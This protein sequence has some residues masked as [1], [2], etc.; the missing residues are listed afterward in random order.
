MAEKKEGESMTRLSG[1]LLSK[2]NFE[3]GSLSSMPEGGRRPAEGIG[4]RRCLANVNLVKNRFLAVRPGAQ[5][6]VQVWKNSGR[7]QDSGW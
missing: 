7:N 5:D 6:R 4:G 2:N 3:D 1:A